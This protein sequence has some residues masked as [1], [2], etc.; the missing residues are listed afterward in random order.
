[1][2]YV[3]TV[4]SPLEERIVRIMKRDMVSEV[5]VLKRIKNQ[6][7]D[8]EKIKQSKFIIQNSNCG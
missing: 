1:M 4:V 3:A 2:D 6:L 7:S 8:E 5:D